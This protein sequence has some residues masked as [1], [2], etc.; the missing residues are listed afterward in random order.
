MSSATQDWSSGDDLEV[1]A[2]AFGGA[3]PAVVVRVGAETLHLRLTDDVAAKAPID[4]GEPVMLRRPTGSGLIVAETVLTQSYAGH[5]PHVLVRRPMAAEVLQRRNLF[6]MPTALPVTLQVKKARREDWV[7]KRVYHHL[8]A[9]A[10]GSGCSIET[11]LPIEPGD[12]LRVTVWPDRPQA[13]VVGAKVA[14][15]G[16]SDWPGLKRVGLAFTTISTTGQD[17][18]VGTLMEEERIRRRVLADA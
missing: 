11:E 5:G 3:R 6:R 18:L 15:T 7:S 9:D 1:E 12:R 17:R 13:V 8:T 2:A 4:A 10:S 14:W 16:E